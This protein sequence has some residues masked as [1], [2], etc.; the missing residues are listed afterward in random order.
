MGQIKSQKTID[1]ISQIEVA[2]S[3]KKYIIALRDII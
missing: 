1:N 2:R 3:Y